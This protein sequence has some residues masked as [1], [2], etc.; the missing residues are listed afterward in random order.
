MTAFYHFDEPRLP[1]ELEE[2]VFIQAI[3]HNFSDVPNIILVAKRVHHWYHP[4]LSIPRPCN[5]AY[6][7]HFRLMPHIFNIVLLHEDPPFPMKFSLPTF[8]RYGKHVQHL[9]LD[10]PVVKHLALF[11]NI[12]NLV[13]WD[14]YEPSE[15][16]ILLTFNHLTHLSITIHNEPNAIH[17]S[18]FSKVTH[19]DLVSGCIDWSLAHALIKFPLLTHLSIL[20]AID[21]DVLKLFLDRNR[22]RNLKVVILWRPTRTPKKTCVPEE[23]RD[24]LPV[25]DERLINVLCQDVMEDWK[26]GAR[27]E[28]DMW[29]VADRYLAWAHSRGLTE[30]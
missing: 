12:T 9:S 5:C 1:P 7:N 3:D 23:A 14:E 4:D 20:R 26:N 22:C 8:Q 10:G 2:K 16:E 21:K 30:V 15:L 17:F 24:H 11:T 29:R 25:E 27:G 13:L 6:N 18:L 19:L 28:D